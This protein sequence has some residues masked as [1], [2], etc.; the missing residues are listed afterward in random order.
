MKLNENSISMVLGAIVILIMGSLVFNY[1]KNRQG[2]IPTELL[3]N[4]VAVENSVKKHTVSK[5]ETLWSIAQ[6]YYGDGFA[7]VDIA[8]EN[9]LTDAS[10]IKEG[11]ELIIPNIE[12]ETE[13]TISTATYEV[14]K[15]DSLWDIAVRA[16]GD[17]YR[18]VE[19]AQENNLTN[20]NVIHSGNILILPR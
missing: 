2:S 11:Q 13:N 8:T 12:A 1:F 3:E 7:W 4:S 20:P 16:Y 15:G 10:I 18:W 9:K 19:I 6:N 17:G 5:G 14:V